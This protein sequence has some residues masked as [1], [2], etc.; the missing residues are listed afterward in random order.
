MTVTMRQ[1]GPDPAAPEW[2]GGCH[3]GAVRF[4]VQLADGMNTA[5]RCTC[6][7][8]RIKGVVAVSAAEGGLTLISGKDSLTEYRFN[9]GVAAHWF[10]RV[11]GTH[12]H[13]ARRSTPGQIAV[14]AACLDGVSPF[15][16]LDLPVADGENHPS[17]TGIQ[18]R[19]GRLIYKPA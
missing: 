3:C 6:S 18:R 19:A 5:R 16:F 1:D 4:R 17:D 9:T 7:Y 15:D 12:T 14:S 2:T 11:C 13:H 10:C 8:C